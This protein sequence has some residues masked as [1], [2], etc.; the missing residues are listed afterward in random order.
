[1]PSPASPWLK[2]AWF[3]AKLNSRVAFLNFS[4]SAGARFWKS[5]L[6]SS[7]TMTAFY[8]KMTR[9]KGKRFAICDEFHY[10]APVSL[11][12]KKLGI[13]LSAPPD[14]PGFQHGLGLAE[15]ALSVGVEVYLYCI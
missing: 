6:L 7:D 2:I 10:A 9:R 8:E 13:L 4:N 5:L 12:G 1:M 15:A 14:R 11:R 3:A